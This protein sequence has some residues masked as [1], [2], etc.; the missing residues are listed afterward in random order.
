MPKTKGSYYLKRYN[1]D[2]LRCQVCGL[3]CGAYI[4]KHFNTHNA[5]AIDRANKRMK[6]GY[7]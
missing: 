4:R 3:K 1:H 6:W 5:E 2:K 7:P